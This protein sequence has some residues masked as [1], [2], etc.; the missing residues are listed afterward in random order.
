MLADINTDYDMLMVE[1]V[2]F[3]DS[4]LLPGTDTAKLS[5]EQAKLEFDSRVKKWDDKIKS[6]AF[7]KSFN[8]HL[9]LPSLLVPIAPPVLV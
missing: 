1:C 3:S 6:T 2:L 8:S 9:L 7:Y 5:V 4:D